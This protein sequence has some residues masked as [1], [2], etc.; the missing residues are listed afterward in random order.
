MGE[1]VVTEV[2]DVVGSKVRIK[3]LTMSNAG[4][5]SHKVTDTF[6]IKDVKFR[7]QPDG[8]CHTLL[9]LEECPDVVFT[10]KD[11]VFV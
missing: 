4:S 10:I 7:I 1:T 3:S 8:R 9:Y 5:W 6:T 11:L 2:S